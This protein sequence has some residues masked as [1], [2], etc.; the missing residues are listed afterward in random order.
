SMAALMQDINTSMGLS[1][2]LSWK[3][4]KD[5]GDNQM[6]LDDLCNIL[7]KDKPLIR[8]E[9][10]EKL[11]AHFRGKIEY[12]QRILEEKGMEVN[13]S[14]LVR[15]VLDFRNW[16][17]FRLLCKTAGAGKFSELTMSRFNTFS[18]GERALSLY[19]PLFAAVGAQYKK[20]GSQAPMIL[21]LD[22][23]FAGVD[24][25]NI[26]EMFG[27][28]EKLGFGYIVN[29]QSL[30]GCY[31]TV[32]GLEIAELLH[33]KDTDF[34]TVILYEWNGKKKTLVT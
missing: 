17:E 34:I 29:S 8:A 32:P 18:G 5:I 12:E 2:S 27:L 24:E 23:A 6:K 28:L 11:S 7:I 20:A 25:N 26:S 22:E 10:Y 3:P 1:F 14:E 13:Y 4:K 30:W 16:F 21:A 33:E 9:D 19:I 15:S 31:D